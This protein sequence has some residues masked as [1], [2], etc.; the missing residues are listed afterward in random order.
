MSINMI[1]KYAFEGDTPED[2]YVALS[3]ALRLSFRPGRNPLPEFHNLEIVL[4]IKSKSYWVMEQEEHEGATLACIIRSP[5]TR[6]EHE[7]FAMDFGPEPED[8]LKRGEQLGETIG[9]LDKSVNDK[10]R[11]TSILRKSRS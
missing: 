1:N 6:L 7:T 5:Y 3:A 4:P 9:V 11:W 10:L 2:F 8:F